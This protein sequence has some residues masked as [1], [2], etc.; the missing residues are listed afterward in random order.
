MRSFASGIVLPAGV[1]ITSLGQAMYH[2]KEDSMIPCCMH[3]KARW[4]PQMGKM[5]AA[6]LQPR[7][8]NLL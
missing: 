3:A 2:V 8:N 4:L 6:Q 1:Q 5:L 7:Q